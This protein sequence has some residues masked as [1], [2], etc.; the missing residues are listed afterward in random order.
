MSMHA[1]AGSFFALRVPTSSLHARAAKPHYNIVL[2][3]SVLLAAG[4]FSSDPAGNDDGDAD[5]TI[6]MTA[7]LLYSPAAATARVGETVRWVNRSNIPHTVTA[8][9]DLAANPQSV[10]LPAGAAP[11]DSGLIDAG[12]SYTRTFTV[13]GTYRYFCRPHE[14]AAMIGTIVVSE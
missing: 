1:R 12:G 7:D 10:M 13:P 5:V 6:D 4:C 3:L 2:V 14:G 11:F 9:P 8:D